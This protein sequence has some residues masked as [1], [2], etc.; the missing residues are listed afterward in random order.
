MGSTRWRGRDPVPQIM[1][2]T[3]P[4]AAACL[5]LLCGCQ[6]SCPAGLAP[7]G[8]AVLYFGGSVPDEA[9]A[10]FARSVLGHAFPDGFTVFEAAGQWRNPATG[11]TVRER[12]RVV[13]VFGPAA[14]AQL[15]AVRAAYR[16]RFHQVTVG[17]AV[18][19][20]CAAF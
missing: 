3:L 8:E 1:R 16:L 10:G 6:P 20:A 2:G 12:T 17:A 19:T 11:E 13:Q 5:P 18:R 9:W 15:A 4:L 7:M 14:S